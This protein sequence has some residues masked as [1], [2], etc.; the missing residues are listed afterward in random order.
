MA[1]NS[2]F[3]DKTSALEVARTYASQAQDKI[4]LITGVSQDGIGEAIA[5]AFA[6]GGAST[7]IITGRDDTRLSS[8]TDALS[9]DYPS[10]KIRPHK[11]DLTSLH[12]TRRSAHEILEDD[13]VPK[14]D[15][16]VANAGGTFHGPRTL[17][18]DGLESHLGINHLGHFLFVTALL[19]KL[20]L[21]AQKS[22]P[23]DTRVVM[24]SSLA[25][26]VSPFRFADYNFDGK[27]LAEDEAPN[28]A[29]LKQ[30]LGLEEHEGFDAE[31]AY[32]QSKTA[33]VLFAV[34]WNALFSS[35]GMYAFAVHPGGVQSR[36]V[37]KVLGS[38]TKEQKAN[39][40]IP[41]DKDI[42]QGAAT[43]LIAA[44]DRGLTPEKGVFLNDCQVMEAPPYAVSQE[45]AQKLWKLS[46]DIIAEKLGSTV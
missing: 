3:D 43:P 25:T 31:V 2:S 23:G 37:K 29:I 20:R 41:F 34:H 40:K 9:T 4:V 5:R 10:V 38:M 30:L 8:I 33:N 12:A 17:T 45:K 19:P 7:I 39:I 36:A 44:L 24:M 35:E 32:G 28:W 6:H 16:V 18:P 11:L 42:Y 22:V 13:T 26:L 27:S 46:E 21:A 1:S 14:I 15:I